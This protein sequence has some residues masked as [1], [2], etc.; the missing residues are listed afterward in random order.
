[1]LLNSFVISYLNID[2]FFIF[3]FVHTAIQFKISN[4]R[5]ITFS[6]ANHLYFYTI[7]THEELAAFLIR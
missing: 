6:F 4:K 3:I 1:M 7:Q 2:E 5:W